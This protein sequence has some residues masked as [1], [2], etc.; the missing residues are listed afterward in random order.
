[1]KGSGKS[2][3]AQRIVQAHQGTIFSFAKPL[4]RGSKHLFGFSQKELYGTDPEK[5]SV[6]P[7]LGV[8]ARQILQFLGTD[9]FRNNPLFA[10]DLG[11]PAVRGAMDLN[12]E[13]SSVSPWIRKMKEELEKSDAVLAVIDDVRFPDELDF[14]ISEMG[15]TVASISRKIEPTEESVVTHF[16]H[17]Q[18]EILSSKEAIEKALEE[19]VPYFR[20][21]SFEIQEKMQWELLRILN[22]DFPLRFPSLPWKHNGF[23][24]FRDQLHLQNLP[25]H[26]ILQNPC[27]EQKQ[28]SSETQILHVPLIIDNN[29]TLNELYEKIDLL[30]F[31]K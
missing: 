25:R 23:I 4:K 16:D 12:D 24:Q 26:E 3:A 11:S 30:L 31:V 10:K 27:T 22:E 6:N 7:Y 13:F 29:G 18:S 20:E 28:H 8:S 14:I 17:P 21:L 19:M 5:S 2:V 15:G 9:V 1:V